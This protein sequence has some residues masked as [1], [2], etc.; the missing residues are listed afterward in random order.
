MTLR[1]HRDYTTMKCEVDDWQFTA[2]FGEVIGI[3]DGVV[4]HSN[5]FSTFD[6]GEEASLRTNDGEVYT[7]VKWMCVEFARRF[8]F[9]KYGV[10]FGSV[11]TAAEMWAETKSAGKPNGESRGVVPRENGGSTKPRRGDLLI[12][13]RA[14]RDFLKNES[15]SL[16][17]TGIIDL[18]N[19]SIQLVI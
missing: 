1:S 7:G 11:E 16:N 3:S 13:D 12:Y 17:R 10:T 19:S 4:A 8:W 2:R 18:G 14:E 9:V 5:A 6:S 15:R